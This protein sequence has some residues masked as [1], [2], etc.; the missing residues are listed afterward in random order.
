MEH[1]TTAIDI[2]VCHESYPVCSSSRKVE[3]Y[4]KLLAMMHALVERLRE[5]VMQLDHWC[6]GALGLDCPK[7]AI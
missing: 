3:W 4:N 7:I 2:N 6:S 1:S 5:C